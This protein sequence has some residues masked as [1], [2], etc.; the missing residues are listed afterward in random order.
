MYY[1]NVGLYHASKR[2]RMRKQQR[3]KIDTRRVDNLF[4]PN[5]TEYQEFITNPA[6]YFVIKEHWSMDG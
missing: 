2:K 6:A 3:V 5:V 1:T 4:S